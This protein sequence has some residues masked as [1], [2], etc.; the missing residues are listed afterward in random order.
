MKHALY[1]TGDPD[2]PKAI[3]DR[4]GE[5]VLGL[6]RVCGGAEGSLP[7]DCPGKAIS[8]DMLEKV[9]Y[10]RIDFVDGEWFLIKGENHE[11]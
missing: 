4:N 9:A 2:A 11:D 7:T 10:Q 6:C 5:V 3:Q 1:E 8:F